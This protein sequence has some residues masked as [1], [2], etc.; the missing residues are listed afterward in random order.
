MVVRKRDRWAAFLTILGILAL[1]L[2]A[3]SGSSSSP[4][5]EAANRAATELAE[6]DEYMDADAPMDADSPMDD[7]EQMDAGEHADDGDHDAAEDNSDGMMNMEHE[8]VEAPAEFAGLNNPYTGDQAA[9][10]EGAAL[11]ATTCATCHGATGL[12]DGPA[13]LGLDPQPAT[14]ADQDMMMSMSDG[15]LFWRVSEGGAKEPFNSAMPAWK[16]V[17]NEEQIWK[18]I[19]FLRTLGG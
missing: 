9:I 2:T 16:G 12:G 10:A 1:L 15:Y 3:C 19:A 17:Y 8:H 11:F 18:L 5:I 7:D 4:Q 14:L 13:A 6:T